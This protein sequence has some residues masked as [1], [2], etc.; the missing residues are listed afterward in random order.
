MIGSL[1]I[2]KQTDLMAGQAAVLLVGNSAMDSRFGRDL[3][4]QMEADQ[5]Q[6]VAVGH[7]PLDLLGFVLAYSVGL[8]AIEV[9]VVVVV[10]AVVAAIVEFVVVVP[11]VEIVEEVV[12]VL[13][14]AIVELAVAAAAVVVAAV[15]ATVVVVAVAIAAILAVAMVAQKVVAKVLGSGS[16]IPVK[17]QIENELKFSSQKLI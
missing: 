14:V 3:A 12:V 11:A 10:A 1:Q 6:W 15:A 13:A 2:R 4:V 9:L 7:L 17:Y 16:N 8:L 5:Q